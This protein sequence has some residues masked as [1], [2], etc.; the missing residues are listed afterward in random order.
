MRA[1]GHEPAAEQRQAAGAREPGKHRHARRTVAIR[2]D[3]PPPVAAVVTEPQR[4]LAARDIHAPVD[5][6]QVILLAAARHQLLLQRRVNG[7]R[8]RHHHDAGGQLIEPA[9]QRRAAAGRPRPGV[10]E[11]RVHQRACR[12]SERRMHDDPRRLVEREQV[13]ILI[14]NG[15]RD[16]LRRGRGARLHAGERDCHDVARRGARGHAAHGAAVD[17]DLA[18]FDPRLDTRTR[19]G[20]HIGQVPAEHQVEAQAHVPAIGRQCARYQLRRPV[21]HDVTKSRRSRSFI[22]I[23]LPEESFVFFVCFVTRDVF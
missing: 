7:R 23:R 11:Q 12:V 18:A 20:V 15:E 17:R 10:P 19:R 22:G 21:Y 13:I 3:D 6:S 8:F 5:D 16:I 14:E 1:T 9:D 4:N 2:H